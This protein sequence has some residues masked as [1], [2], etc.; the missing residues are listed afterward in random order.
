MVGAPG[1]TV[2]SKQNDSVIVNQSA[3]AA[4]VFAST[5]MSLKGGAGWAEQAKLTAPSPT[6]GAS[7]GTSIS[8][9]GGLALIGAPFD[10]NGAGNGKAYLYTQS[11]TLWRTPI[12]LQASDA[13]ALDQFGG[14]VSL[15]TSAGQAD[16]VIGAYGANAAYVFAQTTVPQPV[17]AAPVPG[18]ALATSGISLVQTSKL[19]RAGA[20]GLGS[21]AA[22]DGNTAVIAAIYGNNYMGAAFT[23]QIGS[24]APS[25]V[26]IAATINDN[27]PSI[28]YTGVWTYFAGRPLGFNDFDND[29]HATYVPGDSLTYT[30]SGTGIAYVSELSVGYGSVA[31]YLDGTLKKTVNAGNTTAGNKG[32]QILFKMTGLPTGLHTIKLV[33]VDNAYTLLDD[34]QVR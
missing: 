26:K 22:T 8:V 7:F 14:S 20:L 4:Y 31:I 16:A 10:K 30:F 13:A 15:G 18:S 33:N 2:T 12:T 27:D 28:V 25:P 23:A 29:V 19:T 24:K 32:G 9:D 17:Q 3:G 34:F 11:G 1:A 5:G 6:T 21:A